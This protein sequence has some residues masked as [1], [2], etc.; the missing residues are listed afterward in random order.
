MIWFWLQKIILYL[1]CLNNFPYTA[2]A[3]VTSECVKR[4]RHG[5]DAILVLD[6]SERMKGRKFEALKTAAIEY[7]N[8]RDAFIYKM[9]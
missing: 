7:V 1:L 9:Y 3:K 6:C 5:H 8:G 4:G 2:L